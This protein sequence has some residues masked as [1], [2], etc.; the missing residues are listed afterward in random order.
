M[1]K[2]TLV[3]SQLFIGSSEKI[4][5][6][7]ENFVQSFFCINNFEFESEELKNCFCSQ[8]QKIKNRQ[9]PFFVWI[10]PEKDYVLGDIEVIFEK[11]QFS[12]D[13]NQQFF[14]VLDQAEK[15]TQATA[16]RLL[17]TLEEPTKG[18]NFILLTNNENNVLPTIKSRCLTHHFGIQTQTDI[19]NHPILS[20][21]LN[22]NKLNDPFSFEQELKKQK[23]TN[24]QAKEL[25][26]QL[27]SF[28]TQEIINSYISKTIHP[29]EHFKNIEKFLKTKLKKPPQ[30]GSANLFLKN[31]FL[32][33]PDSTK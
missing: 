14:F 13:E 2:Q 4:E 24:T 19:S 10:S 20:F 28:F 26:N 5:E 27:L 23:L 25:I 18:Y 22:K 33:F 31:I 30:T 6:L 29:I 8:C 9:H 15:L 21:F 17:K 1:K 32:S 3:P 11:T 16:N 12:L 7:A